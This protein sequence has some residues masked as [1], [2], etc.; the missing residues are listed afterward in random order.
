M[1]SK[2]VKNPFHVFSK[3]LIPYPRFSRFYYADRRDSSAPVFPEIVNKSDCHIFR[4][5]KHN[6]FLKSSRDVLDV[7]N[8]LVINK[9]SAGPYLAVFLNVPKMSKKIWQS[10]PKP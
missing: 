9:R 6:S 1:F 2:N 3:I 5:Y 4:I 10:I 7:S 8:I